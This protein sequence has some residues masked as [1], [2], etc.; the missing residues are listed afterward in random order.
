MKAARYY[1][2]AALLVVLDQVTKAL[3]RAYL[4]G[5]GTVVLIPGVVGLTYVENT[6]MA[7]S[8]FSGYTP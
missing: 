4:V 5:Q 3:T 1:L 6:G 2:A 8:S 7:F